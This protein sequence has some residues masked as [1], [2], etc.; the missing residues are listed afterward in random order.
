MGEQEADNE[1]GCAQQ[2]AVLGV[3][4]QAGN[5]IT[6][7]I[8]GTSVGQCGCHCKAAHIDAGSGNRDGFDGFFLTQNAAENSQKRSGK[9]DFPSGDAVELA[10]DEQQD[11]AK[12]D[13]DTGSLGELA[14]GLFV[15]TLLRFDLDGD[16]R[17]LGSILV[18]V[19]ISPQQRQNCQGQT[20]NHKVHRSQSHIGD[21]VAFQIAV[22]H[23]GVGDCSAEGH[24]AAADD[25][26][27]AQ[28]IHGF[29]RA[30]AEGFAHGKAHGEDDGINGQR[31]VEEVGQKEC[32]NQITEIGSLEG[33]AGNLHDFV[34]ELVNKLGTVQAGGHD[35]HRD[36]YD[37]VGVA[38]TG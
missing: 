6:Y 35:E 13:D 5:G 19:K 12:E 20:G 30:D 34:R 26:Y 16:N 18:A 1:E 22:E 29:G 3:G 7:N 15:F 23:T 9:G 32:D 37:V 36:N 38:E 28:G 31:A 33:A 8:T 4:Q 21:A 11:G 2:I 27:D 17:L 24:C 25:G 10:G 14:Q